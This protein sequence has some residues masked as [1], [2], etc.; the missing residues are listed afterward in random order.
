MQ[1]FTNLENLQ[2]NYKDRFISQREI[3]LQK[4]LI[5]KNNDENFNYENVLK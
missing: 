2:K 4:N 5:W 3:P 1:S